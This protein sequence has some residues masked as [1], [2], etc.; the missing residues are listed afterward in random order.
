MISI[1][2]LVK[3]V[4]LMITSLIVYVISHLVTDKLF[5]ATVNEPDVITNVAEIPSVQ[6]IHSQAVDIGLIDPEFR[7]RIITGPVFNPI[8]HIDV[9]TIEEEDLE[10]G[11]IDPYHHSHAPVENY[12]GPSF[13]CNQGHITNKTFNPTPV[14]FNSPTYMVAPEQEQGRK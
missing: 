11:M 9:S 5:S 13:R 6:S 8:N 10:E 4:M 12:A 1:N 2:D 3:L 7:H 14:S